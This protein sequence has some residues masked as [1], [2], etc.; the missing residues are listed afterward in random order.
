MSISLFTM[1]LILLFV[2]GIIGTIINDALVD[3]SKKENREFII[4]V[5]LYGVFSH[6]IVYLLCG[7][8]SL[9]EYFNNDAWSF[10][11]VEIVYASIIAVVLSIIVSVVT[12]KGWLYW[13]LRKCGVTKKFSEENVFLS[14]LNEK[15]VLESWVIIR[16][17]RNDLMYQGFIH[18]YH[19]NKECYEI[20][21]LDTTVYIMSDPEINY[22]I[23]KMYLQLNFECM[24][25]EISKGDE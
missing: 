13:M 22:E 17:F 5:T 1:R 10:N 7:K 6:T 20:Y 2:P 23:S 15:E 18:K 4:S 14:M 11:A 24:S 19:S 3:V 16:D 25:I 12:N 9:L 21:L 8:S